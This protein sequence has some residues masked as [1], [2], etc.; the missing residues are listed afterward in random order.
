MIRVDSDLCMHCGNC[1][2]SCGMSLLLSQANGI[3]APIVAADDF[4]IKCGHCVAACETGAISVDEI[5]PMTSPLVNDVTLPT[6]GQLNALV[7]VRRSIRHYKKEPVEQQKLERL[8]DMVRWAP[9][10]RNLLPVKWLVVND[11]NVVN[12]LAGM[13]IDWLRPQDV[14]RHLVKNWDAGHDMILRGAP[15]LIVACTEAD[16][17]WG[18]I[19]ATI[20]IEMLELGANAL[21]LG[22]CW[23]GYFIRA[24][25]NE[26]KIC[27]RL[28][29]KPTQKVRAALMIGEISDEHYHR[30]PFRKAID[31]TWVK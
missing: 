31:V 15:C 30:T 1:I 13:V 6:F 5:T 26:S 17:M 10:A 2:P 22:T 19:D 28:G 20:A 25:Q 27:K 3:P 9:S 12:E 11:P 21:Q 18:D 8:L 4:C 29:L 23:A 16:A 14:M 24:S 7:R